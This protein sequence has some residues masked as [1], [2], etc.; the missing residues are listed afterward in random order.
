MAS[1]E[2]LQQIVEQALAAI[3]YH[4]LDLEYTRESQGWVLRVFIDHPPGPEPASKQV[5]PRR[6]THQ[7][8]GNASRHLGTVLDVED[9]IDT[10]YRLEVSSPGVFRPLR[11]LSDFKRFEGF[12]VRVKT[13]D[14]IEGRKSFVGELRQVRAAASE[15]GEGSADDTSRGE[16]VVE[17]DG[18]E[19]TLPWTSI[20]KA[21]LDEEY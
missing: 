15:C 20:K 4:V 9:P 2:K 14:A 16:I 7:D 10:A 3:G 5:A 6:I 17:V 21:R 18:A 8:C 13:S 12:R 19:F 1:V 11:K